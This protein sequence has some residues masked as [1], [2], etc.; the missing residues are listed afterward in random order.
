MSKGFT[1]LHVAA[2]HGQLQC[3]KL[4]IEH[5][6]VDVNLPSRDGWRALH[7]VLRQKNRSR[8]KQCL[9]YLLQQGADINVQSESK[10]TPL[11]QAAREGLQ[12]CLALLVEKGADVHA[13]DSD[14]NRP[15]DLCKIWCH[16]ACARYL[17]NAMWKKEKDELAVE[18]KKME[19][20]K[21]DLKRNLEIEQNRGRDRNR[22]ALPEKAE[23]DPEEQMTKCKTQ[24]MTSGLEAHS[25]EARPGPLCKNWNPSFNPTMPPVTDIYRTPKLRLGTHAEEVT[26]P[27][28]SSVVV[29]ERDKHG[30][31]QIRSVQGDVLPAQPRLPYE[32][33]QRS[34]FPEA[35]PKERIRTPQQFKSHHIV[36][37][38]KK[39]PATMG[40]KQVSEISF[41]L[42][43]NLDP[44]LKRD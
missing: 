30:K 16:R 11:H 37:V 28:L 25:G 1:A 34:L 12:E 23:K 36:D 6:K 41:H 15:I 4:L 13:K 32:T 21:E 33:I 10:A 38:P 17:Q 26:K 42:R 31:P 22:P 44:K 20:L 18:L 3:L 27:D 40:R 35:A 19:D 8:A 14:G 29:L 39:Q 7:S 9:Q 2:W 24:D 5:Y 43:R